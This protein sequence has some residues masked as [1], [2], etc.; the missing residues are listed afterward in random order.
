MATKQN[1][2]KVTDRTFQRAVIQ[3]S[4][5]RPVIVDFWAPWC[6]P[7]KT[8]GPV[9]EDLAAEGG[10]D[11]VLAKVNVDDNRSSAQKYRVRG[12]PAVKAFVDGEVVDDFTGAQPRANIERWLGRLVPSET[13]RN[14]DSGW[15]SLETG[16]INEAEER[17]EK[18]LEEDERNVSA[19]VGMTQVRLRQDN[20]EAARDFLERVPEGLESDAE[21]RFEPTWLEVQ[22][23]L[24]GKPDVLRGRIEREGGDLEARFELAMVLADDGEW[25]AAFEQLL[26]IVIRDR[27]WR[28]DLGRES[29]VR[30]FDIVDDEEMVRTWRGKLGQAMY[31]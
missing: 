22:A 9:L 6:G 13:D 25:E 29:M 11:W 31:V 2:I 15:R 23:E 26:E 28:D 7:C 5:E 3:Q 30:L 10:G 27:E 16:D 21:G 8:L 19:L 18:L 20:P 12:I 14:V 4:H 24:A 17:F 1:V